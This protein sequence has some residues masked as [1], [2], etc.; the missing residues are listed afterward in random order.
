MTETKHTALPWH[1]EKHEHIDGELWL[2]INKGAIDITHNKE[3]GDIASMR[4]SALSDEENLANAERI[5]HCIN[6]FDELAEALKN[7]IHYCEPAF[8][9][10]KDQERT[11]V[12][13]RRILKNAQQNG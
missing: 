4:Y 11:W 13:A 1:I 2:T 6:H 8:P 7:V 9:T 5:V 12:K 10:Y 3:E